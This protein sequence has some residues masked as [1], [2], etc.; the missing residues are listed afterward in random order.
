[1][2][3]SVTL[4]ADQYAALISHLFRDPR[5]ER[6]AYLICGIAESDAE[7]RLLVRDVLPVDQSEIVDSSAVHMRIAAPS[8]LRALKRAHISQQCF[9]FVHSHP[10][11]VAR[12]SLQ[13]DK[14]EQKL[15]DTAYNRIRGGGVHAS[16][17]FSAPENPV[18]RVWLDGGAVRP[19][20]VVRV[21][22]DRFRF[23]YQDAGAIVDLNIYDRQVRAFGADLQ[24]LIK[25]LRIG[26]VGDG[27]TG[28]SVTEQLIRLGVGNIFVADPQR[29]VASNVTRVYGSR[30]MDAGTPKTA[31]A[32]R[33]GTEIGL[34]TTIT[35]LNR[36]ITFESALKEFRN[37]DVIFGCTDDQWGRSLLNRLSIYYL[38]PVFDMAAKIDSADGDIRSVQGRVTTL[39]PGAACLFCRGRISA[40]RVRA[41]VVDELNPVEA[42][43]LRREGYAPELTDSDPAV[44]TFTTSIAAAAINQFLHRLTG[45]M[46]SDANATEII[47]RFDANHI[48]KNR[49]PSKPDCFCADRSK[50][51]RGDQKVFLDTTWRPE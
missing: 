13:D 5:R 35:P 26:V 31:L 45:F 23:F 1:M 50:W 42:E 34:G 8:Y 4:L 39:M 20:D 17:V 41:E 30:L 3:Y 14:E 24:M 9:I 19:L 37:C 22:G 18:G 28:S 51:G 16:I 21:I 11:N 7:T 29:L 43:R 32:V 38:L 10:P 33:L 40:D 15:F 49:T 2:R 46:G 6:A 36:P 44:I 25:R 48:G 27:G 12:H 47:H